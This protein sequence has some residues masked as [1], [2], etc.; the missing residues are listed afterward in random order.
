MIKFELG[1]K[2]KFNPLLLLRKN[3][4]ISMQISSNKAEIYKSLQ[5]DKLEVRLE[6]QFK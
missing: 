4:Y 1:I 3:N 6:K 2:E 5:L